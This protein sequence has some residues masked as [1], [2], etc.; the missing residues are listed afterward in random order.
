MYEL[1]QSL[2][3]KDLYGVRSDGVRV[4]E[5]MGCGLGCNGGMGGLT[6]DGSGIFGTGIFGTG[7]TLTDPTTWGVYE[8]GAVVLGAFVLFSVFS[9]SKR[10]VV[11]TTQGVR[12]ARRRVAKT[13]A[14]GA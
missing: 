2:N 4:L 14:G 9:T 5:G 7:V 6:M 13:I 1:S 10:A 11:A 12:R 8:I 3:P